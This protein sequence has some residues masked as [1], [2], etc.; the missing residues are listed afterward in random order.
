MDKHQPSSS[1]T[2]RRW[3]LPNSGCIMPSFAYLYLFLCSISLQMLLLA[4]VSGRMRSNMFGPDSR[5]F[6]IEIPDNDASDDNP[7][8]EFH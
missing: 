3:E 8:S 1:R 6:K 7:G 4:Y 5:K 2:F